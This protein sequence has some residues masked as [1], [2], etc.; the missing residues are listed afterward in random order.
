MRS[1]TQDDIR[2]KELL[3]RLIEEETKRIFNSEKA[4]RG[5]SYDEIF[6]N[7]KQG[8][9]AEM[10]MVEN[11]NFVFSDIKWHDLKNT[12]EEYCEVKAYDVNDETAHSVIKDLERY[13]TEGWSKAIWYY[14]FQYRSAT[15][16]LL[17]I[18]RIK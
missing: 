9:V 14:L 4:R 2:D 10:Y 8:K 11:E 13:R 17:A 6:A 12:D 16:K 3:E 5:R 1:F 15:Y 18:I 7:V